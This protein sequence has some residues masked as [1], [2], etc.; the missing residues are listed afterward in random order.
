[1]NT[2]RSIGRRKTGAVL[3]FAAV[4]VIGLAARQDDSPHGKDF[5]ISCSKCH[6]ARGWE[7][8][9]EIYSFDHNTTKL[10]LVGQHRNVNCRQCNPTLV[11]SEAPTECALCHTDIHEQTVGNDCARCHTPHS[12]IVS[13]ITDIHRQGRFPLLGAHYMAECTACH[14]SAS[15]LRFEPIGVECVDCHMT[16]YQS[17]ANPNHVEGN[18]STECSVCHEMDSYS[19]GGAGFSHAFFPLT[20]GHDIRDC[21]RCHTP[22]SFDNTPTD[23]YAC[24]AQD[25]ANTSNPVHQVS[26]FPT[27]CLLCHTTAPGWRPADF[28][29]HDTEYFPIYSGSHRS[30]WT[31][32]TD[33]HEDPGNYASFTCLSCHEHSKSRTDGQ[34]N[35]VGAYRYNSMACLDCHPRGTGGD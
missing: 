12:W 20:G 29:I 32:C 17:A 28:K 13:N 19:W 1:V 24:H 14:P 31:S 5:Q 11:F 26:G 9:P 34:H 4:A 7:I 22:G 35:E 3:L 27:D 2:N 8:D 30:A 18:F 10:P 16:D 21:S 25:Y 33:C 15:L 23:C 6:S